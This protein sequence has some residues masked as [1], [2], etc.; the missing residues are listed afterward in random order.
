MDIIVGEQTY[1]L[2]NADIQKTATGL[3][4]RRAN[5]KFDLK[6]EFGDPDAVF[7]AVCKNLGS[8]KPIDLTEYVAVP[9]PEEEVV[10]EAPEEDGDGEPE[11]DGE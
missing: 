10:E 6:L 4:I 8:G 11:E 7:D 2:T 5:S 1:N 9:E 3:R